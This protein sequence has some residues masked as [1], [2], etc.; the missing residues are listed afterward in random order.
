MRALP[1]PTP[2]GHPVDVGLRTEGAILGEL[3]RRGYS[4]LLPVRARTSATTWCSTSR[5]RFLRV[6]C[7]TGR[8]RNGCVDVQR[9]AASGRIHGEALVRDYK[10]EV[11]LFM[12]HCPETGGIYAVPID[13]ATRSHGTLRID[14]TANGQDK[15]RSVGAGLRAAGVAQ[16]VEHAI[17]NHGARGSS[18]LSGSP[19]AVRPEHVRAAVVIPS[20]RHPTAEMSIMPDR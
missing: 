18:P 4:V 1:A 5:A 19:S 3:V 16:L 13:E 12:V 8:L 2:S 9:P 11:E 10:D 15:A 17:C 20:T 14:P 6:Q 7:K